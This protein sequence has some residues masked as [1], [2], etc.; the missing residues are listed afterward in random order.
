M[1]LLIAVLLL[2]ASGTTHWSPLNTL[3]LIFK[4]K[5]KFDNFGVDA[6]VYNCSI[7]VGVNSIL[8]TF[9]LSKLPSTQL[10]PG[11]KLFTVVGSV[12]CIVPL[13][14]EPLPNGVP[15]PCV[16]KVLGF[17]EATLFM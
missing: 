4:S 3:F 15:L 9:V 7:S 8:Y 14:I 2:V 6:L 1:F 16:D 12:V 11:T 5:I 13:E 10:P 17:A